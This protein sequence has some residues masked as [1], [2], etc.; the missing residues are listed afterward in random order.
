MV[1]AVATSN[2]NAP[3]TG[4]R[5][6]AAEHLLMPQQRAH[7]C[8][9]E[10]I[11]IPTFCRRKGHPDGASTATVDWASAVC[12][13]CK[14]W[15]KNPMNIA[16]LL[17]LL[18]VGVSGGMFVLLLLGLLDGAFPAAA[19]RNRWIEINVQVLNALFT[20]MSL[21]QHP[22]LCHHLFLLCRW[23]PRDAADLRAAYCK[24]TGAAPRPRDRVHMAV[25]VALL[26][27][28]VACQ[29]V[30]C[31]LYWGYS[32]A[33]RPE[34]AEA[35]FFV[36]G[37]VAPVAAAV[38]TVCSP[39]GKDGQCHELS[40]YDAAVG[41]DTKQR[42]PP[43]GEHVVVEPEWAGGMFDCGGDA[44]STW[45]LSLSCTFCV[46]GWNMERLGFGNAYVHAVTF[47]L[48]CFAPLWVL[49]VSALHI[50]DYVIGDVVG[51]AG[52]LLC[53]CGLL[54]GGYWR[55]QMRR[56]FG[57][58]GSRACCGSKSLTDYA[59]WLL[60]WPWALAQEVRTANLYHVDGEVLYSKVAD[61][62][63]ADS[64]KPLL[65]VSNDHDVF[66][67]TETVAVV[68]QASPANGHLVVVDDETTMAPPVQV[69]VVQQLE[70]DKSEESSVSLQG[71]MSNSSIPTSVPTTVR[72]EDAAL[73]ESNRAVTEEDGHGSMPSDGSWRV[74]KV[75][76]LINM[77]TLVSLLILLY[78]RGII[79]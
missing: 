5:A 9:R 55:I 64:R 67:A 28:T 68:S 61:N 11:P 14:E 57:L 47:A 34:L 15:L 12:R 39:L 31:G 30:Q 71:E 48:L 51:G 24:G 76:K 44:P 29:Y 22:A 32:K 17:W 37:V 41:S 56:R 45:C 69:V 10:L 33:I 79:L 18:C 40:F 62:D 36:L 27:L 46:F 70:G 74:E 2:A 54:Y 16:L 72:E 50:H 4:N 20:L 60:C 21:Y 65:V 58:P 26:H 66:R 1:L 6:A 23:R 78:T 63:H 59:R 42:I 49:G 52:A 75:K 43:A 38:Y 13:G 77:V 73:L 53:A 3:T 19:E 25:V 7:C 35:G 8:P